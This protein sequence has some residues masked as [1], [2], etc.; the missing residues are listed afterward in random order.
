MKKV[1]L[2]LL[3]ATS[4]VACGEKTKAPAF[5]EKPTIKIGVSLPLSGDSANIGNAVKASIN[6]ALD[7]WKEKNTKYNYKVIFEDDALQVSKAA[8]IA[9]KFINIDKVN[10]IMNI[11]GVT[12]PVVSEVAQNKNVI[13]FT[14]AGYIDNHNK[15]YVFN[16]YT[17]VERVSQALIKQLKKLKLFILMIIIF[18]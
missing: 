3:M 8:I 14:C 2:N 7:E 18:E 9:N 4:L 6:M 12:A 16:N 5:P 11:W 1:L 13:F 10:A 17:P 15:S